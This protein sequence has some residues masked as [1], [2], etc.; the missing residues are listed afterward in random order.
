VSAPIDG[1][2]LRAVRLDVGVSLR[3]VASASRMSHGH[4]SKVERGE[5]GRPVTPAVLAAYEKATGVRITGT[6]TTA[7]PGWMGT[8]RRRAYLG[9]VAGLAVGGPLG[10]T[11]GRLLDRH[12]RPDLPEQLGLA[13]VSSL[14]RVAGML[15]GLDGLAGS[16]AVVVLRWAVGLVEPGRE[17][18]RRVHAAVAVLAHR[19]AAGAV[20]GERWEAARTLYLFALHEAASADSPDL[21][22]R[23]LVDIAGQFAR[24]GLREEQRML[25]RFAASDERVSSG[26]RSLLDAQT[27]GWSQ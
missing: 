9:Q 13:D 19:G 26:V 15:A 20:Q 22:A 2:A 24:N 11:A 27:G 14:E 3:K 17:S 12:S 10:M 23:V 8:A 5:A 1:P 6:A 4:L 18:D 7:T 25:L 21:R 16:L